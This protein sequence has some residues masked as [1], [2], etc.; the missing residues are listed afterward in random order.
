M[1][2]RI[3]KIMADVFECEIPEN[4]SQDSINKWDSLRHLNFIIAL[5][6][7]FDI[8]FEPD[9]IAKMKDIDTI[10]KIISTK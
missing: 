9:E 4:P 6:L 3:T 2:D 7:E 1:R 10:T 5:E 8:E